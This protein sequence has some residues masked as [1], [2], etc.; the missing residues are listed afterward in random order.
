MDDVLLR[1]QCARCAA[2][3]CVS[4][5]FDR[6]PLFAFDKPA[7][8]ACPHLGS[9][10]R[11][12]IHADLEFRGFGGCS[13]YE[14]WGAGQR[15]T[16][17]LFGGRSWREDPNLARSMFDAFRAMR[18]VHELLLL[19]HTA[20]RLP[21]TNE[22]AQ[23]HTRLCSVLQPPCGWSLESLAAFEQSVIPRQVAAFLRS[24]E[25]HV[26]VLGPSRR[27]LPLCRD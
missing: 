1:A 12:S 25:D 19:L 23:R 20:S 15:V 3:C 22:Q 6:S 7:G 18:Q 13:R 27:R 5:A 10:N 24:L 8:A 16:Q 26:T 21:L 4:L 9:L 11:C 2:L 14:C 17:E